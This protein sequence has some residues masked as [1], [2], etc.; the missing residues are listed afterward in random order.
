[1]DLAP[2]RGPSPAGRA[3]AWTLR[4]RPESLSLSP[5]LMVAATQETL[6]LLLV[7]FLR[8][9]LHDCELLR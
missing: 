8:M 7:S 1:M 4:G 3:E 6:D 9:R 5:A 2:R